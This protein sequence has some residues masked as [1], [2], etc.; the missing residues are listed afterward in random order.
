VERNVQPLCSHR[1]LD[2]NAYLK[3]S[4]H[5]VATHHRINLDVVYLDV[6]TTTFHLH[7]RLGHAC[8]YE[9][10]MLVLF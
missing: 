8:V 9:V 5:A 7:S 1:G 3:N 6:R 4:C 10:L 2:K